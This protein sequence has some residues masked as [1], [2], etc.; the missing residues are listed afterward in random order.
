MNT[1]E[2]V[3]VVHLLDGDEHGEFWQVRVYTGSDNWTQ[4]DDYYCQKGADDVAATL[5]MGL[6]AAESAAIERC[7]D[8]NVLPSDK[9]DGAL[10]SG[11]NHGIGRYRA[12]I[13]ALDTD[14]NR[15]DTSQKDQG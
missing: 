1:D 5:R 6:Q 12:A 8:L 10:R 2:R 7:H 15:L 11:F 13:R 4:V 3:R 14:Q 9:M